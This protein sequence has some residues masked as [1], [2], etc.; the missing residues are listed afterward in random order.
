MIHRLQSQLF[1]LPSHYR[2]PQFKASLLY[3]R[4]HSNLYQSKRKL[5]RVNL[6]WMKKQLVILWLFQGKLASDASKQ[7]RLQ[8]EI[9]ILRLNS[10]KVEFQYHNHVLTQTQYKISQI[11]WRHLLTTLSLLWLDKDYCKIHNFTKSLWLCFKFN[12]PRFI[13]QFNKIRWDSCS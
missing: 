12:N 10:Y 4:K 2:P 9:Q 5:N 1:H 6:Q 7:S 3:Q 8:M 13:K 11:L